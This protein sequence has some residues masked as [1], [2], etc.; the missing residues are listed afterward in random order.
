MKIKTQ[1][2]LLV[3]SIASFGCNKTLMIAY[4]IQQPKPISNE[5]I[6]KTSE[7]LG[8][9]KQEAF[10]LNKR[11]FYLIEKKDTISFTGRS[12]CSEMIA[13]YQQPLQLL[14]FNDKGDLIS[15]HNNCYAPGFPNLNWNKQGQFNK[16]IPSTTIPITD[17]VITSDLLLSCIEP[18]SNDYKVPNE[19]PIIILFW[20][21]F[22]LRQSRQL[23]KI[24]NKNLRLDVSHSCKIIYV[25]LDN[26]FIDDKYSN[27]INKIN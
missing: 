5:K 10:I 6:K 16:F 9:R 27:Q 26:C 14:Y 13:K 20:C 7:K 12:K 2:I 22:M 23:I 8:I 24:A 19:K 4:G 21:N 17:T 25:N 3:F 1:T 18:L 15:F 11:Y